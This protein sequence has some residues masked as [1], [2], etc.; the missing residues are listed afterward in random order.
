MLPVTM[1][2]GKR[3]QGSM[4][5]LLNLLARSDTSVHIPLAKAGAETH[6]TAGGVE[7]TI[8]ESCV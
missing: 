2:E 5:W 3:M 1:P 7:S 6:L 4:H 8:L